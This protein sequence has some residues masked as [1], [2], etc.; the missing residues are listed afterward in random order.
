MTNLPAID[1]C[2]CTHDRLPYLR[3]C[4]HALLPQVL[5][6]PHSITVV[7]NLS[8]PEVRAYVNQL[9]NTYAFI[10]YMVE[11]T[12]GLSRARNTGW[13]SS[14]SE[15]IFYLDDDCLPDKD[16]VRAATEA[17]LQFD[18]EAM[19]GPIHPIF[20][21]AKPDWV[22]EG[23]GSFLLRYQQPALLEKEFLRGG[24][25]LVRRSVLQQLN[26]FREDLGMTGR[27]AAY[28]E[29]LELQLRMRRKGLRIGYIPG[30]QTGHYVRA[31]KLNLAWMLHAEFARRRDKM[32]IEPVSLS[33][34]SWHLLRTIASRL[35]QVPVQLFRWGLRRQVPLKRV[36]FELAQPLAYRYGEWKGAWKHLR[37]KK[38]TYAGVQ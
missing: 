21:P 8:P 37:E 9:R 10:R 35:Y 16:L 30:L 7:D 14:G 25:F 17:I 32:A 36:F 13:T 34:A 1:F 26:G 3:R 38:D 5:G 11:G 18:F 6:T 29:E 4:L 15:W 12:A 33:L 2:I 20:E 27:K 19:G 28:G 24:C 22:P 31:E 23:F